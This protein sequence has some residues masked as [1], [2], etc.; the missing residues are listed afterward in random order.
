MA[1]AG[2]EL[3]GV[4]AEVVRQLEPVAVPR[5]AHED[6]DRLVADRQLPPLLEP[7][8]LVESDRSLRVGDAVAG[9][10]ELHALRLLRPLEILAQDPVVDALHP[11]AVAPVGLA[12]HALTNEAGALEVPQRALVER[13]DLELDAV[14]VEAEDEVTHEESRRGRGEAAAAEP[15]LEHHAVEVGDPA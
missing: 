5:D 6:V 2:P 8:R 11:L 4:D 3:V 1:V 14:V 10:D 15:R 13:V 7:E 9:V 12:P